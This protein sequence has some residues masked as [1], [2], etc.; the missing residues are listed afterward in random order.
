MKQFEVIYSLNP[1]HKNDVLNLFHHEW[2][3]DSRTEAD[4]ETIINGSSF[5]VGVVDPET[6]KL[7]AF[8]RA[9]TDTFMFAYI[10][11]VIVGRP[12]RKQGLGKFL[13]E[14]TLQHPMIKDL[15][16]VEL[17]CRKEMIPFYEPFGFSTDYG[18]SAPI[19]RW[20][21]EYSR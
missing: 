7:V 4:L 16:S 5:I 19:R 1:S 9:L 18:Q 14:T 12:Y 20:V 11:D 15:K 8:S 3:T 17:I 6:S 2:W 21:D 13:V 10:Y